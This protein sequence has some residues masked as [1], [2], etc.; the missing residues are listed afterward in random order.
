MT[1]AELFDLEVQI[2]KDH[3]LE[4]DEL[5]RR[6][7]KIG[8]Q[9]EHK[10]SDRQELFLG[11]LSR[12]QPSRHPSP[13]QFFETGYRWLGRFLLLFGLLTG[14]GTAAS[15][16]AYDGSKPVNVVNFLAIIV[17]VQLIT[18][19]F[20]LLYSLPGSIKKYIPGSGEFYNFIRELSYLFSRLIGKIIDHL[21]AKQLNKTWS[22]LQQ[23]KV[24][25]KLYGSVEKWLVVSLTQRFGLGFNLGALV[26]CLYLIA[27]SDLAFAW[28]TTLD[29]SNKTFHRTVHTIALPW[30]SVFP[31][32]TPS[33]ELVQISRYYRL[34][35]QYISAPSGTDISPALIVGKWWRFL[36][37][38][39]ITYGLFPRLFIFLLS[40]LKLKRALSRLPLNSADFE[41]LYDRLTRPLLETRSLDFDEAISTRSIDFSPP[42]KIKPKG[43]SCIII[44]WGDP[45]IENNQLAELIKN[46]FGW[47]IDSILIAGSLDYEGTDLATI[48][49]VRKQR[50]ADPILILAE[51]WEAPDAALQLFLKQLREKLSKDHHIIIAL[52]NRT[53]RNGWKSP[54]QIEWQVWKRKIAELTDPFIRVESLVEVI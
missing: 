9:L 29:I 5:R 38:S 48:N 19:F 24:R 18:I 17:G 12:V 33:L 6:D 21:P 2:M 30:S 39:L 25:Q 7:R 53:D 45:E 50:G 41:S 14:S 3:E 22:D 31:D 52:I 20:F 1:L 10:K 27:F 54:S 4:P 36:V 8:Q 28:N 23:L 16:L 37:L 32:A 35:D 13:G 42:T 34:E 47:A 40:K 49:A 46:R 15:V 11:W 51:S 26:T 44:K 43:N